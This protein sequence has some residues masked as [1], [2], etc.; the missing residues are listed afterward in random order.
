MQV[1]EN[2][3][4][5]AVHEAARV[6]AA[7]AADEVLVSEMARALASGAGLEFDDRGEHVLKGFDGPRRLYALVG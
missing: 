5:Q 6:M 1:G 4:G 2:V 3:R 7:A